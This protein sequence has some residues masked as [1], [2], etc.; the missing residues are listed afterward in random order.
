MSANPVRFHNLM[1]FG[2]SAAHGKW[3]LDGGEQDETTPMESGSALHGCLLK[4]ERVLCF[5]TPR[6]GKAFDQFASEN[7]GAHIL[8][9]AVY[10]K[11]MRMIE[12]VH[13]HPRAMEMLEG[14]REETLL[15]K[16]LGRECRS[17][18]DVR[19]PERVVE[20]KSARSSEPNE[21]QREVL[22]RHYHGQMA[23]QMEAVVAS[24][25][26]LPADAFIVAVESTEPHPV[27]VFH[28]SPRMLD[29]GARLVRLWMERLKACEAAGVFPAYCEAIVEIDV[30]V[31]D[32]ELDYGNVAE[33]VG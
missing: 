31:G 2:R 18:P 22:R 10:D 24:G 16:F 8:T 9:P 15:F 3:S 19:K 28:L 26:G 30:P 1:Q 11:T 12:A 4:G 7:A 27:T 17:T 29:Y 14:I 21:F 5:D 23:F 20:L 13:A 6:R 25:L 33:A 32:Q